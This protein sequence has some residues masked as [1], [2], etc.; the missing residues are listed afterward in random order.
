M[1]D[2]AR[3]AARVHT[4]LCALQDAPERIRA[5]YADDFIRELFEARTIRRTHRLPRMRFILRLTKMVAEECKPRGA[6]GIVPELFAREIAGVRERPD[7][8]WTGDLGG[9]QWWA[10]LQ[11]HRW[12]MELDYINGGDEQSDVS[13]EDDDDAPLPA[14]P[15]ASFELHPVVYDPTSESWLSPQARRPSPSAGTAK[16]GETPGAVDKAPAR[17]RPE[18]TLPTPPPSH[19]RFSRSP[20]PS[21]SPSSLSSQ[22]L[23]EPSSEARPAEL[24]GPASEDAQ[25]SSSAAE[26]GA[27]ELGDADAQPTVDEKS[28]RPSSPSQSDMDLDTPPGSPHMQ[29]SPFSDHSSS[30]SPPPCPAPLPALSP[31]PSPESSAAPPPAASPRPS[32]AS[33]PP[34]ATVSLPRA[35]P[36]TL[37]SSAPRLLSLA[38]R[39]LPFAPRQLPPAPHHLP[40]APHHLSPAPPHPAINALPP[41]P[42]PIAPLMSHLRRPKGPGAPRA[43]RA[44]LFLPVTAP[45]LPATVP[46]LPATAQNLP[47]PPRTLPLVSISP[48]SPLPPPDSPPPLPPSDTLPPPPS[49]DSPQPPPSDNP[50]P[51]PDCPPPPPQSPPP[52]PPPEFPSPP[53]SS[54]PPPS[55]PPPPPPPSVSPTYPLSQI[56]SEILPN[57]ARPRFKLALMMPCGIARN[58]KRGA[59]AAGLDRSEPLPGRAFAGEDDAGRTTE[60][61]GEEAESMHKAGD[62]RPVKM[63]RPSASVSPSRA[64]SSGDAAYVR[65]GTALCSPVDVLHVPSSPP[66]STTHPL[67]RRPHSPYG[68][69]HVRTSTHAVLMSEPGQRSRSLERETAR[70]WKEGGE[71]W[72]REE[73]AYW[74][75]AVEGSSYW[76]AIEERE[77]SRERSKSGDR[78][79]SREKSRERSRE[80]ER[81]GRRRKSGERGR[82]RKRRRRDSRRGR[83]ESWNFDEF[84][85]AARGG[86]WDARTNELSMS[87]SSERWTAL[88]PTPAAWVPELTAQAISPMSINGGSADA[89]KVEFATTPIPPAPKQS[90]LADSASSTPMHPSSSGPLESS[91]TAPAKPAGFF[92]V[93]PGNCK[94]ANAFETRA[95][96]IAHMVYVLSVF[97]VGGPADGDVPSERHNCAKLNSH[98][99]LLATCPAELFPSRIVDVLLGVDGRA[100]PA[101]G[102][103]NTSTKVP[104]WKCLYGGRCSTRESPRKRVVLIWHMVDEHGCESLRWYYPWLISVPKEQFA[105]VV[106]DVLLGI[107]PPERRLAAPM[108]HNKAA[109]PHTPAPTPSTSAAGTTSSAPTHSATENLATPGP[110]TPT[111]PRQTKNAVRNTRRKQRRREAIAAATAATSA[112]ANSPHAQ[113]NGLTPS[114]SGDV[115]SS[116]VHGSAQTS[117]PS[118]ST[119]APSIP[120]FTPSSGAVPPLTPKPVSTSPSHPPPP[121]S[122][123]DPFAVSPTLT[124]PFL[125]PPPPSPTSTNPT[126]VSQLGE[127]GWM[128]RALHAFGS[129]VRTR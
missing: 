34:S 105:D 109:P 102:P 2:Y 33:P 76:P 15:T 45:N 62:V 51:P 30:P 53:S 123:S 83:S 91:P 56:P 39:Q 68:T 43:L 98:K 64:L 35:L 48:P 66:R 37:S 120:A 27:T 113:T 7:V 5:D 29:P 90:S 97:P 18:E 49:S 129:V 31:S 21:V 122:P 74:P 73:G 96:A 19:K 1:D 50:P 84:G 60:G 80:R 59:A 92:C 128:T 12:W 8:G 70:G 40:P 107:A 78:D 3:A 46:N 65:A 110:V 127:Q 89:V 104:V 75:V 125:S 28:G 99:A 117:A 47:E 101:A 42:P 108:S 38:Q 20:T 58:L 71:E 63:A 88:T 79:R 24:V 81:G 22:T 116:P 6:Y 69:A 82:R 36:L 77:V 57:D 126:L 94:E 4:A 13:S 11:A 23:P 72:G 32:P 67:P 106:G 16:D 10:E 118:V 103:E 121:S 52:P 100:I 41:R 119:F 55:A 111:R 54:S 9:H 26:D 93:V 61:K 86:G 44:A 115:A 124:A 95:D 17:A 112:T 14:T 25:V 85:R 87:P 114:R